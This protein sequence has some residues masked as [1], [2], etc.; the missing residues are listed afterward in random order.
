MLTPKETCIY[1]R[2]SEN[3][4]TRFQGWVLYPYKWRDPVNSI[5]TRQVRTKDFGFTWKRGQTPYSSADGLSLNG[6]NSKVLLQELM[7]D[8]LDIG[9][10]QGALA[11]PSA[12]EMQSV[13][14]NSLWQS[15]A[16]LRQH[17][18]HCIAHIRCLPNPIPEYHSKS[19]FSDIDFEISLCECQGSSIPFKC[20]MPNEWLLL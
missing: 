7:R 10:L 17:Q 3:L 9:R 12:A 20:P 16:L 13:E 15:Q 2:W 14:Q 5:C 4:Y 11:V 18:Q 6:S 8:P 1:L 19:C